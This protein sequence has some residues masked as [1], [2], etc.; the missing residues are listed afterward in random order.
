MNPA[1]E[2]APSQAEIDPVEGLDPPKCRVSPWTSRIT[3]TTLLRRNGNSA[4]PE[5]S[6][7]PDQHGDDQQQRDEDPAELDVFG[8][9]AM[10]HSPQQEDPGEPRR[11]A[12]PYV[13]SPPRTTI[14]Q[15]VERFQE[16]DTWLGCRNVY[17]CAVQSSRHAGEGAPAV[18]TDHLEAEGV[19]PIA[20]RR[21]RLRGWRTSARPVGRIW[22]R[23][24][25][26]RI[27]VNEP[28]YGPGDSG[29]SRDPGHPRAR[30]VEEE[31]S[32]LSKRTFMMIPN[33][34]V[35]DGRG[36]RRQP[37]GSEGRPRHARSAGRALS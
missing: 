23:L 8:G 26:T 22:T 24:R 2:L 37:G 10:R 27:A 18:K 20:R 6:P 11:P 33:P 17:R 7:G 5:Q 15:H 19:D 16:V 14:I 21:P 9:S 28:V 25:I 30:P 32:A 3:G 29:Q 31:E 35:A 12:F 1:G 4:H 36:I 13:P 34:S